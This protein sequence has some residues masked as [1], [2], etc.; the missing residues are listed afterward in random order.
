MPFGTPPRAVTWVGLPDCTGIEGWGMRCVWAGPVLLT[1]ALCGTA[2]GAANNP[3]TRDPNQ[4]IN[5]AYTA[6]IAKY[7]TQPDFNTSLTDYL[8]ASSTVPTPESVLGDVAGAPNML[9]YA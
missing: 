2:A 8:P 3:Y 9:P 5:Q 7:T 6:K 4:P 1:I